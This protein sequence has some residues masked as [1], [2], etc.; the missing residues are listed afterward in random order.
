MIKNLLKIVLASLLLTSATG[1]AKA[2][3]VDDLVQ[4]GGDAIEI[5][6]GNYVQRSF[7]DRSNGIKLVKTGDNTLL[8]KGFYGNS[9]DVPFKLVNN[10]LVL[11]YDD[12]T[13]YSVDVESYNPNYNAFQL[14]PMKLYT[15]GMYDWR[16]SPYKSKIITE[17]NGQY[18]IEF[19]IPLAIDGYV[20]NNS[21]G[22]TKRLKMRRNY[23]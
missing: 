19:D 5:F 2:V 12:N 8:L 18:L 13:Y 10:R 20:G 14:S 17:T 9:C 15:N 16:L 7:L 22:Y 21:S 4:Y 6:Y 3:T 11:D 23:F 1:T